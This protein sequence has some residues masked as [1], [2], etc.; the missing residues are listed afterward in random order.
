MT[1]S[2]PRPDPHTQVILD[3][4]SDRVN[5][6]IVHTPVD[7][8]IAKYLSKVI[9]PE[10]FRDKTILEIGAGCSQYIPLF[11]QYG[12]KRYYANDIIPERLQATR[13]DDPRYV[14][15][16]GDFRSVEVPEKVDVVFASLTMMLLVPMFEDF[17]KRIV[18]VLKPGGLFLSMDA[19]HL[20][21]L[22]VYRVW[23]EKHANPVRLFRPQGYASIFRKHGMVIEKLV[24]FTAPYPAV[25]GN[26]LL[27]TTFWMKARKV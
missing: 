17:A 20:C 2:E 12:C 26:W 3:R 9:Q 22:S 24:P 13:V 10:E 16:P 4:Y 5:I 25:T 1:T 7:V 8:L 6:G 19:N 27:G 21:P 14:E 23:N 11:M 15:L 18:D